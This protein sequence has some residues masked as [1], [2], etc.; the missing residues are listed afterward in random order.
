MMRSIGLFHR[1]NVV[2]S[3]LATMPHDQAPASI[4]PCFIT[5]GYT[6]PT[7]SMM[8]AKLT[9]AQRLFLGQQA[10]YARV[11]QHAFGVAQR[12]HHQAR[13]QLLAGGQDGL[14]HVVA[15]APSGWR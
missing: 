14:L 10:L 13:V 9:V 11:V 6:P 15:P 3:G 4:S 8:S 5:L 1:G 2:K 7:S 12:A